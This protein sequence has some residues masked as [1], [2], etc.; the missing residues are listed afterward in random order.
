MKLLVIHG[1]ALRDDADISKEELEVN[2]RV[3]FLCY[4]I[5]RWILVI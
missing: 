5:K 1:A 4:L 3:T 2:L